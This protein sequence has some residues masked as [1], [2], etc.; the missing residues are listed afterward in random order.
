MPPKRKLPDV[1]PDAAA[2]TLRHDLAEYPTLDQVDNPRLQLRLAADACAGV[3]NIHDRSGRRDDVDRADSAGVDRCAAADHLEDAGVR[4]GCRH[5]VRSVDGAASLWIGA[6][7]VDDHLV[8][9]DR[10]VD[11][12]DQ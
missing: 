11:A 1:P 5:Q 6:A 8:A 3:A 12:H 7:P 4:R 10:E 2:A 9:A